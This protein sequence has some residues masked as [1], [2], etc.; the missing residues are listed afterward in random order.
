MQNLDFLRRHRRAKGNHPAGSEQGRH[1]G[2]AVF[3]KVDIGGNQ[4]IKYNAAYL[5]GKTR[6]DDEAYR[7]N[8]FRMQLEYEF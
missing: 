5:M 1:I 3:G 2:P 8:T 4:A 7:G 6:I